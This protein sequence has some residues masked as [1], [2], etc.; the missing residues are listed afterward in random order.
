MDIEKKIA[1]VLNGYLKLAPAERAAFM[2]ALEDLQGTPG[3]GIEHF[4][5]SV[6][7]SVT[8]MHTGPYREACTCCGRS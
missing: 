6:S 3:T 2:R 8:K 1:H 7:A 5:E 4:R